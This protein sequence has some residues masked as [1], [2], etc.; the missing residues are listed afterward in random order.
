MSLLNSTQSN[1][2]EPVPAKLQVELARFLQSDEAIRLS[3][4][5]DIKP[6]GMYGQLWLVV[7]NQRLLVFNPDY[8][9]V[10]LLRLSLSEIDAIKVQDF[11]GNAVLQVNAS[12]QLVDVL[13]FSKSLTYKFAEVVSRLEELIGQIKPVEVIKAASRESPTPKKEKRCFKC[14]QPLPPWSDICPV[15]IKKTRTVIRLLSLLKPYWYLVATAIL[16]TAVV[17]LITLV[18]PYLTKVLI[19]DVLKNKN[20]DLLIRIVG[21]LVA[22]FI[23]ISVIHTLRSLIMTALSHKIIYQLRHQV[24]SHLQR[25]S[26]K[27]YSTHQT[28]QI[29]SRTT[30]DTDQVLEFMG[31]AGPGLTVTILTFIGIGIVLFWMNWQLAA[32]TLIPVPVIIIGFIIFGKKIH[33]VF[34]KMWRCWAGMNTI[35]TDTIP[36]IKVV[37]A[38]AQE[39]REINRF[40]HEIKELYHT[41]IKETKAYSIFYPA[42]GFATFIGTMIIWAYG[43]YLVINDNMT[44]GTLMAFTAY[45]MMFYAPVHELSQANHMFQRA[46]TSAERIFGVLDTTPEIYSRADSIKLDEIKG[47]VEFHNVTFAYDEGR[48]ALDNISFKVKAAEIIGLVG[49]SGAGKTTTINLICRFWDANKGTI[50]ID[51]HNIRDIELH[52]LRKQIGVVLQEPFLFHGSVGNNI[53]YGKPGASREEIIASSK[54]ANAH[55]FIMKMPK[56]YDTPVG[57]RGYRLS[58]GERQRISIARAILDDPRILILDEAT[59]SVDTEAEKQIQEALARLVKGRTTF[60]I[61]HRLSTLKNADRLIV[62]KEGQLIEMGT[63]EELLQQDGLYSRLIKLQTELS[64]ITA[65][66]G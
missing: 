4:A 23:G 25:L 62:I 22:V 40:D 8:P 1:L 66:N 44:L 32:L 35:L 39:N 60:A 28:G 63:H 45:M 29:M 55:G 7:T 41:G 59:S 46:A 48:P 19:D 37:K 26:L 34:H 36:G 47:E 30:H 65:V 43:G 33:P 24:Y 49:P 20:M 6:D 64:Q 57:E 50:T 27:F 61:A 10:P 58:A 9:E 21:Y 38:F 2:V 15:C 11:V 5:T 13:R 52:S 51:G 18:P 12:G 42:M 54:A 56:A 16:L 3:V 31:W 14:G 17:A 53:A